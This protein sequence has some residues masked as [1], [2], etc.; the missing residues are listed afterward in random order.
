MCRGTRFSAAIPPISSIG[1][2]CPRYVV[3]A[4]AIMPIVFLE[5][6]FSM[7]R[8]IALNRLSIP[9]LM[10]LIP[11]IQ[12]ALSMDECTVLGAMT[13]GFL[14]LF[15]VSRIASIASMLDSVPPDVVVPYGIS[16]CKRPAIISMTSCSILADPLNV[17]SLP[18]FRSI[19]LRNTSAPN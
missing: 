14:T 4:V 15:W 16:R 12:A 7:L 19:V 1:S 10:R 13:S 18:A 3:P 9:V 2:I 11:R 17:W 8:L 6:F 5:I